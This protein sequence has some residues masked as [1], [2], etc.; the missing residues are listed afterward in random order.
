[1]KKIVLFLFLLISFNS[2]AQWNATNVNT[3]ICD[4]SGKQI[5]PRIMADGVGGAYIAWKDSR[6]SSTNPD[7][8]LQ[9][10]DGNGFVKWKKQGIGLCT[11]S[12]DQ[13]TPA[14][15][16]D[17]K[18]GAIVAWS[19][20]RSSVERDL[21]AQ[22][23]DSNGNIKWTLDGANI[24]NL[25]QREHS[26]KIVSDGASG[27]IIAFEKQTLGDWGVWAQRLDSNGTKMWGAG[28]IRVCNVD[29]NKT[30]RNHRICKDRNGGAYI[31]WQD[32][33]PTPT[34][35]SNDTFDIY[36]QH[37]NSNG[38]LLWGSG[39]KPVCYATNDQVN[40]KVDPDSVTNGIVVAWQDKRN[41]VDFDIYMQRM[42]SSGNPAWAVNGIAVCNAVGD[43][44][45]LD[46]LTFDGTKDIIITWK[47]SRNGNNDIYAQKV[48]HVGVP[49][50]TS[51]GIVVCNSTTEQVNPNITS[52]QNNGA[53]IV[54][55]DSSFTTGWDVKAQHLNSAGQTVWTTNGL[56][57]S[58]AIGE[59]NSPKN[60]T[61]NKGGTIICWQ[62][63]RNNVDFDIYAHHLY[64]TGVF[65]AS[66]SNT[67][68]E[69]S[70]SIYPNP[71]HEKIT[72]K[73][74]DL[75]TLKSIEIISMLGETII[76]KEINHSETTINIQNLSSG[77]YIIKLKT[78]NKFGQ[79][80]FIKN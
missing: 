77:I 79:Y 11:E 24:T 34:T 26:E 58:D 73:N 78:E 52:D 49:Q 66:V 28:G 4:T 80:K 3:K 72:I 62:D 51:N 16:S 5:D 35:S 17:M 6:V 37:I 29:T 22:R 15:C 44:S 19:D 56:V 13:S 50:W 68:N 12:H 74:I 46:F 70:I 36:A 67:I 27:I 40:A 71:S 25:P 32:A 59:Q 21:Y 69:K 76:S 43:Q 45:A 10:I 60:C 65:P 30:K 53:I 61:D 47:D 31:T 7:I 54:W 2:F 1:M 42:D 41:G 39:G 57:V 63:K 55:Q 75:E 20:W 9:R 14:I 48:N 18:G 23:I 33:R 8:Y 64:S 38:T